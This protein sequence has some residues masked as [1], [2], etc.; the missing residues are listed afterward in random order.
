MIELKSWK[1]YSIESDEHTWGYTIFLPITKHFENTVTR[2]R[3]EGWILYPDDSRISPINSK[4]GRHSF[5]TR[6]TSGDPVMVDS[7]RNVSDILDAAPDYQKHE[8]I[9]DVFE[10]D[11]NSYL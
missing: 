10:K 11:V 3:F 6:D 4:Y 8:M 2:F 7:Y 1:T 5:D 9:K